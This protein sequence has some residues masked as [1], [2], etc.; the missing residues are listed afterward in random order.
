MRSLL[1]YFIK[2]YAFVL[3]IGLE[4][5]S[6]A[7]VFNF[8][9]Y[10]KAIYLNTANSVTGTIYESF[11]AVKN[12]FHLAK[13]NKQLAEENTALRT[14]TGKKSESLNVNDIVETLDLQG[15]AYKYTSALVINNS[16]NKPFNYIT[17]NKGAK[18]GVRP[19]QGIITHNGIV[20]VTLKVSDS[21]TL[22]MSVLNNRW[23][24]SAKIKKNNYFG[25]LV[26]EG[27]NYRT[28]NLK[29]IPIHVDIARGDT[30]VTSGFSSIF[31]E[32]I[33][34]GTIEEFSRGEGDNYY[35]I[36][37]SLSTD[38][39]SLTYVEIIENSHRDEIWELENIT[40]DD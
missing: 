15:W 3:F 35:T 8:N 33:M 28:A 1:R 38:F 4:A 16:V 24:I 2:N 14:L 37:L 5:I 21:Y 39:K 7:L 32:G 40:T 30:V 6:I 18:H 12:Y 27:D 23:S 10:H 31:P 20:G 34:I 25:S 17:I 29:E 19:D 13:I 22:V 26:W 9:A 36:A 11:V